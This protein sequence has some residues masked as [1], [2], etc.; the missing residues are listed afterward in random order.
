MKHRDDIVAEAIRR[1]GGLKELGDAVGGITPQAVW[2]WRRIPAERVLA[3]EEAT[4][5]PRELLRPDIYGPPR[6]EAQRP[7]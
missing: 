1:A 6:A 7:A 4:G 3:V 2:R 5:L